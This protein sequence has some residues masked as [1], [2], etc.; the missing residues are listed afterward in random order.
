[1]AGQTKYRGQVAACTNSAVVRYRYSVLC[2]YEDNV[3]KIW[4]FI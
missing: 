4:L 3:A 1:M 2:D